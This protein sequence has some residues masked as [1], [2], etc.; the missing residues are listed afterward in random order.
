M[1]K[2]V[3]LTESDLTKIVKK[4]IEEDSIPKKV[5]ENHLYEKLNR[6]LREYYNRYVFDY[7]NPLY[8]DRASALDDNR[9]YAQ[10]AFTKEQDMFVIDLKKIFVKLLK[11]F[12]VNGVLGKK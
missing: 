12:D 8:K 6:F 1:K 10:A 11:D 2:V 5:D 4:I 9:E 3:R 7:M